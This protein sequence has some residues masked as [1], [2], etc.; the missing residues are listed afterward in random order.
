MKFK[1]YV[2]YYLEQKR[3]AQSLSPASW[4]TYEAAARNYIIPFFGEFEIESISS[5]AIQDFI[6]HLLS[7]SDLAVSSIRRYITII[8]SMFTFA[9]KKKI[10]PHSPA[11]SELLE[12]PRC[13]TP[14]YD[15]FGKEEAQK[16]VAALEKEP[17]Q[18]QL[19]IQL[20]IVTGARRG[21]LVA[22][23]FS[24]FDYNTLRVYIEH[25]A[26]RVKGK[27]YYKPPKDYEARYVSITRHLL[28]MVQTLQAERENQVAQGI[29]PNDDWVFIQKNGA[30][31]DPNRPT[32]YFSKFLK[33]N[34][35]PYHKFHSLRH[36][37]ATLLLYSGASVYQV[38]RRL[39][40]A[41]LTT[42]QIYLHD[43]DDADRKASEVLDQMIRST[44][45]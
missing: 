3:M 31:M 18:M 20:A 37:S 33:R 41:S 21:E 2:H 44:G 28:L 29:I 13:A 7:D 45:K 38:M 14:R 12:L 40:H 36:T 10:I 17:L 34:G 4:V 27:T 6:N 32:H 16:I 35:L 23:K 11:K 1:D 25:S 22:L 9:V 8:Q 24:D 5:D 30:M 42:T 15:I 39:G 43:G 19:L 26:S